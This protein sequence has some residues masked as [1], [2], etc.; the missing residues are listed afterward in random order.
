MMP[1]DTMTELV[2]PEGRQIVQ[3][4]LLVTMGNHGRIT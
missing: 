3:L 1:F 4:T 2:E